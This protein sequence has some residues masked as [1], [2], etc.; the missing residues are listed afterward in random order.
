LKKAKKKYTKKE[1]E[2][3]QQKIATKKL[4]QNRTEKNKIVR[5]I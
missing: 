3:Y 2:R 1:K 4:R 5:E